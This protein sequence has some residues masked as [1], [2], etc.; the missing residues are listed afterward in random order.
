MGSQE[1]HL[2]EATYRPEWLG[3]G[4]AE[5]TLDFVWECREELQ[6]IGR[7][8]SQAKRFY[9]VGSG[10][11]YAVQHPIRYL[12]E[13]FSLTPVYQYSGWEFL[14]RM[15]QGVARDSACIFLSHSGETKEVVSALDWAREKKAI[16]LGLSRS[17]SSTVCV[18]S[19]YRFGYNGKAVTLGKLSSLYLIF[20]GIFDAK[21]FKIGEKMV[22]AVEKLTNLLPRM[23]QPSRERA[24]AAGQLFK[25][26]EN[27][28]VV[29][30][31]INYGLAYQFALCT[32]MEMCWVNSTPINFSEFRH[33]PIE[34]FTPNSNAIFLK[35]RG[36]EEDIEDA[37]IGF[38][39]RNG[40]RC[41]ICDSLGW[42]VENIWTP[43]TL[44]MELEW[45]GYYLSLEKNK[46]MEKW[47]YYDKVDF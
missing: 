27:I 37:V 30:G 47:R 35:G 13:R 18:D 44:F 33:G 32:L 28:F 8:L 1:D 26:A 3:E 12:A 7:M 23:I 20:G 31:G 15:P 4:V 41:F 21:G 45:I 46:K 34:M 22:Q 16:T 2:S 10:G 43:F 29:G 36:D 14:E 5:S 42:E 6:K 24:K 39:K 25:D 17:E 19:E 11:S 40:V 38:S 9:L